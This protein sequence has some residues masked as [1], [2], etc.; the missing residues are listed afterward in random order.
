MALVFIIEDEKKIAEIL[1]DYL[2]KNSYQ[3]ELL[4]TGEGALDRIQAEQPDLVI[5]DIMLPGMS[6]FDI[7]QQLRERDNLVPIIMLTARVGEADRLKGLRIGADDYVCKP[8]LP[9]EVVARVQAILRRVAPRNDA[10][11]ASANTL[12]YR[13]ICLDL[14]NFSCTVDDRRVELTAV[15]VR[16]LQTMISRPGRVF[17]RDTLID[18]CYD[19]HRIISDRTIDSHMRNLRKKIQGSEGAIQTIYGAGYKFE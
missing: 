14:D 18:Q 10:L 8:F 19:D 1:S 15:E 11:L 13:N 16:L 9:N 4:F 7:C 12:N 5:M 3:T 2:I 17:S 6:G